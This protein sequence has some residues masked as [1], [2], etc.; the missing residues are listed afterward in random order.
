MNLR[1]NREY[2]NSSGKSS[3]NFSSS[4]LK[5]G[6]SDQ[7][8]KKLRSYYKSRFQFRRSKYNE[9]HKNKDRDIKR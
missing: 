4:R 7:F 6:K 2:I 9:R 3:Y 5:S 1:K 8:L